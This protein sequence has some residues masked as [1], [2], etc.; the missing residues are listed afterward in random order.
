MAVLWMQ[1]LAYK[2]ISSRNGG[3]KGIPKDVRQ[4]FRRAL[5]HYPLAADLLQPD[6]FDRETIERW[7]AE[8]DSR[9]RGEEDGA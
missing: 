1:A 7:S 5:K 8:M 3:F 9:W 6:A 4:Q 2:C